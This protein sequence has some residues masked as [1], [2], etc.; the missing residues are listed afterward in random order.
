MP[1]TDTS[2]KQAAGLLFLHAQT[3]L[4]P[5]SGTALGAVDLP[6]QRERHTDW[7]TVPGSA[8]KGILRDAC[9]E[10]AK[11]SHADEYH[12]VDD[13]GRKVQKLKRSRRQVTNEDDK[14]LVAVFGPGKGDTANEHAGALAITDARLAAFPVRSLRGVFAW[15]TCPMALVRLNRDLKLAGMLPLAG[16]PDTLPDTELRCA[17]DSP[18]RVGADKV[19][20]EEFEYAAPATGTCD[21]VAAWFAASATADPL[22]AARLRSHLAVVSDNAFG[23]YARFA[24][25]IVARVALDYQSKTVKDGALFYQEVLPAE[26]LLFAVALANPSRKSDHAKTAAEVLDYL[27]KQLT[28]RPVVQIGG[29]ETVGKGLCFAHLTG[30]KG[31]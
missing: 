26:T 9:R 16:V 20:L 15:V 19:V 21:E 23:H 5:G 29:D 13:N 3:G 17:A 24:T 11:D 22:T 30:G 6:V 25:E 27:K 4:H 2:T 1:P 14:D 28:A 18:L 10:A 12:E 8:L 7:P 31:N